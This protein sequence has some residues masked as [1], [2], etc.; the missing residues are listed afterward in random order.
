MAEGEAVVGGAGQEV[1]GANAAAGAGAAGGA[2]GAAAGAAAGGAGPAAMAV[3]DLGMMVV[4]L[5]NEVVIID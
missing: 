3:D 1:E 2:A 5:D 4:D